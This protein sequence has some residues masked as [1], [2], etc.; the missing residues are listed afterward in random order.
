VAT[1][2]FGLTICLCLLAALAGGCPGPGAGGKGKSAAVKPGKVSVRLPKTPDKYD[3]LAKCLSSQG[4][5]E[6]EL[7]RL[8]GLYT[9]PAQPDSAPRGEN[10]ARYG[11]SSVVEA[12]RAGLRLEDRYGGPAWTLWCWEVS[13]KGGLQ[14]RVTDQ[15]D[16]LKLELQSGRFTVTILARWV[17]ARYLQVS[18]EV[19][20]GGLDSTADLAPEACRW[21]VSGQWQPYRM[22]PGPQGPYGVVEDAAA[23]GKWQAAGYPQQLA[24]PAAGAYGPLGGVLL[25]SGDK[26]A[27]DLSRSYAMGWRQDSGFVDGDLLE[28]SY[29]YYDA[30][31]N[32][33]AAPHL[34]SGL[35][36]RDSVIVEPFQLTQQGPDPALPEAQTRE[37]LAHLGALSRS[38]WFIPRPPNPVLAGSAIAMEEWAS[39]AK[40]LDEVLRKAIGSWNTQLN[41][42]ALPDSA[43][44]VTG[45]GGV[46]AIDIGGKGL[47]PDAL[48]ALERMRA[49]Q[50]PSLQFSLLD[51]VTTD[52]RYARAL[53]GWLVQQPGAGGTSQPAG[54]SCLELRLPAAAAWVVRKQAADLQQSPAVGG[55]RY[56]AL[57]FEMGGQPADAPY[58]ISLAQAQAWLTLLSVEQVRSVRPDALIAFSG[59]P[60]LAVPA[61]GNA[62]ALDS[63]PASRQ[64]ATLV[65]EV[66]GVQPWLSAGATAT[67]ADLVLS[68]TANLR[69]CALPR[70][71]GQ[72]GGFESSAANIDALCKAGGDIFTIHAVPLKAKAVLQGERPPAPQQLIATLPGDWSGARAVWLAFRGIGGSVSVDEYN[73]LTVTWADGGTWTRKLPGG[74]WKVEHPD[75]SSVQPGDVV[76]VKLSPLAPPQAAGAN[77]G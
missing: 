74:I 16:G 14:S 59:A 55:Y 35:P 1:R 37:V 3:E 52:S 75:P 32:A 6:K 54:D 73:I 62:Y 21:R 65:Y 70:S 76:L 42:V 27:R 64:Y 77:T 60:S 43:L 34:V 50:L 17:N 29:R 20:L 63:R 45:Y 67:L 2:G 41:E 56:P 24:V 66:F 13:D 31:Q 4:D 38:F 72:Y 26:G 7:A 57:D 18:R 10:D 46:G 44:G 19:L 71:L 23:D 22:L 12:K 69:G 53:A 8:Q 51:R 48:P 40:D 25:A 39:G 49:Q 30:V 11:L 9:A 61:C 68:A 58:S 47:A 5:F 36:V 28:L 33:Y 15:A